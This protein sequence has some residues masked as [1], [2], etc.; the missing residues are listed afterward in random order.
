MKFE[1]KA[2]VEI[3]GKD[4]NVKAQS[5]FNAKDAAQTEIGGSATLTLKG[6]LVMIN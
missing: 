3:K 2:E 4:V 6:G 1:A 5:A